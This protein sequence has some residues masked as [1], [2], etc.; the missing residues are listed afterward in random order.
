[1]GLGSR[2][3]SPRLIRPQTQRAVGRD[4]HSLPF[5]LQVQC[6][7]SLG[8][9]WQCHF[10]SAQSHLQAHPTVPVPLERFSLRFWVKGDV[11]LGGV[12]TVTS[13]ACGV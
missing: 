7:Q 6:F 3:C 1:M 2:V 13:G 11:L 4:E 9:A 10:E 12:S 8:Q 5:Q